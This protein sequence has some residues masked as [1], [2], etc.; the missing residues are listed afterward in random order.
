MYLIRFPENFQIRI[1]HTE[2]DLPLPV[3][4]RYDYLR[5]GNTF[6]TMDQIGCWPRNQILQAG[7]HLLGG[8]GGFGSRL[9]AEGQRLSNKKRS[10]NYEACIDYESGRQIGQISEGKLIEDFLQ[11]EPELLSKMEAEKAEKY[12]R[13]IDQAQ[14]KPKVNDQKFFEAKKTMVDNVQ[15]AAKAFILNK[16][17]IK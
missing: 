8:K 1:Y 6:Y 5:G 12:Q 11:R 10:G 7:C 16:K 2:Q 14:S 9:K 4:H 15:A 13:I 17:N 3:L